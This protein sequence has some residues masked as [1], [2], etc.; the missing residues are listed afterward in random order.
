VRQWW[1]GTG[2]PIDFTSPAAERWWREQVTRVLELGVEGIKADDGDGYYIDDDVRLHDGRAGAEAAWHLGGLHRLSLQRAL[3]EVHPGSGVLFGRSGWTSQHATGLTWGGDQASDFWSLRVLVV[4]TLSAAC[5]GISNWSHDVGGYLGHRLVERCQPELL[6]RWV[7][8]GCF[9]P[10]MQAHGRMPQEPWHYGDRVLEAYRGYVTL[11]EQLVPYVRAAA[12]TA[13]RT[14]LPI[15]RPL[16]LTDPGDPRGWST[17]DAYGY[18]PALWV[19]PVLDEGAREREAVLPRGE[20]I[21]TWSGGTV[22]GGSEIVVETPLHRIPV[23]VRAG[24]IV[25]TYPADHVARGLGDTPEAERPLQATLWGEPRL[26]Q[27]AVRL[28]DGLRIGWRHGHWS[29]SGDRD[30]SFSE[31]RL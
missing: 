31:A 15:I 19:A 14:G 12:A 26:G 8:F 29:V 11:H 24:S 10:L 5:S 1:M 21:E 17:T 2:S 18:G 30:V 28:A 22:R 7:Q 25:V 9:T 16:C 23:W 4:A 27:T 13:A 3:D 6:T 20:W